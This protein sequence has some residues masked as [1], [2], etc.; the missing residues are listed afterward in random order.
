[1]DDEHAGMSMSMPMPADGPTPA[2][3]LKWKLESEGNHHL[4][5]LFVALGGV[6]LLAQDVWKKRFP[7]V[8]Y[9]WP[10]CFLLS[11]LFVLV[12]SDTE[13]W[14]F[15]RKPWIQGTITNPEVIQHKLFAVLLLGLGLVEM[16]R[17]RDRLKAAWAAWVFPVLAVVGSVL[18]L[19]HS[20]S[21]GMHGENH[22]AMMARIQTEH[23]SYA[24]TG[25][26]IGLT[27]GL[28]EVKTRWRTIFAKLWP[29]LMIVLG[30]LLM[31]YTE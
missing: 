4:I 28:A 16:L 18:L 17:A 23:Q 31:F 1:M 19:F 25:F 14:P 13:L 7:A 15:G 8:R 10:V 2:L 9:A 3:F 6:F 5:G 27:K 26:G 11:G 29:T 24:A 22:M 21:A 12:Y 30:V 20:H